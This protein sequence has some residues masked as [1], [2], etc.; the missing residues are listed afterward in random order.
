[1]AKTGMLLILSLFSWPLWAEIPE[2][3]YDLPKVVAVQNRP[4]YLNHDLT[5]QLG[6]LPSDPFNKGYLVGLSYTYFFAPYLAWEVVNANYSLNTE[7]RLK[8]DIEDLGTIVVSKGFDGALDYI[9][10]YATTSVV[11]TPLY[12]KSLLF[13]EKVVHGE[14][15]FLLGTGLASF[16]STGWRGLL[17]AGLSL[18]FFSSPSRSWKFDFRN[19]LYFEETLGPV[20]AWAFLVGYSIQLGADP[21]AARTQEAP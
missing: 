2:S 19:N 5:F 18:R 21:S 15:S 11:Y 9:Q 1:M 6:A 3:Y 4:Y 17:M 13:N 7:T 16:R 20:N 12:N 14:T 10:Y 8:N